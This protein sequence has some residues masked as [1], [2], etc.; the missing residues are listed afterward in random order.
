MNFEKEFEK[1]EKEYIRI[2]RN[3]KSVLDNAP[4]EGKFPD[5]DREK[6]KSLLE[7]A[8]QIYNNSL[9]IYNNRG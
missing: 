1:R 5:E 9:Q 4:P 3:I 6:V 2:E 7:E 8:L